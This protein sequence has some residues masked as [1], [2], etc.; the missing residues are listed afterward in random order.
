MCTSIAMNT[1]DFYFG[2]TMDIEYSFNEKVVF[3]P[4]NYPI[5]FRRN[6]TLRR[7]YAMLGMASVVEDYPLYAEAVNERG[8]CIAGL[9][10]PDNA[11][12]PSKE[13]PLKKKYFSL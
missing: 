10:F 9:N 5:A 8:L 11:Y 1:E 6:D 3:T 13:D 4:R 2:R 12:Y 7:H